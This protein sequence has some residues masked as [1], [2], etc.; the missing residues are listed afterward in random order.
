M[1][2]AQTETTRSQGTHL[3]IV[4]AQL[5][6]T[7]VAV[8]V[9]RMNLG[10][11]TGA[12]LVMAIATLNGIV[13]ATTLLGVRRNGTIISGLAICMLVF[14]TGLLIWP[15]WDIAVRARVF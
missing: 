12:T 13:V 5:A 4:G 1:Q 7:L 10:V 11:R 2:L 8:L 9:S 6:L 3:L 14:I 15:A